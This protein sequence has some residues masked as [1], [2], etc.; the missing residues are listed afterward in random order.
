[1]SV[2]V[3][4]FN[5][6]LRAA[7]TKNK[8]EGH[9]AVFGQLASLER[10]FEQLAHGAFDAVLGNP[11][12]DVRAL[13]NHDARYLLGRQAAGT[14]RVGV[15]SEGLAFDVDLPNTTYANDLRESMARGDLDG[16]SFAFVP[17]EDQWSSTPDGRK[18]RTHTSVSQLIDVSPVT[19]PAYEG[20]G[21]ALRSFTF[22]Q[23]N[24]TQSQLIRARARVHLGRV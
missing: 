16:A 17:G 8:L 13:V 9:A 4:R 18:L 2:A 6:Q 21:V 14:L 23:N 10:H 11:E 22:A 5:V 12:T 20:A 3:T 19:F 24:H 1:M 7:I 15:D